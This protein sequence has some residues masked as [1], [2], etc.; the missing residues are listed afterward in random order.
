MFL[1]H[2]KSNHKNG[3]KKTKKIEKKEKKGEY[4]YSHWF[5][6]LLFEFQVDIFKEWNV[7]TDLSNEFD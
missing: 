7:F 5:T 1:Q 3:L 2:V 4:K 6:V